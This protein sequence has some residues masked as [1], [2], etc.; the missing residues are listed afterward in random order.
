[1][2]TVLRILVLLT[3][4]V[5]V[6]MELRQSVNYRPE[7][8][9]VDRAST[10]NLV[11]MVA[12]GVLVASF[13]LRNVPSAA[14]GPVTAARWVALVL[15]WAGIALRQWSFRTLGRYFTFTIET[16]GDQPVIATGPYRVL[17]HPSYTGLLLVLVGIGLLLG[18]WLSLLAVAVAATAAL[19]YR[20]GVEE[21][22]LEAALGDR[23]REYAATRKRLIPYVW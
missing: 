17:R 9:S 2:P 10:R 3:G 18:N 14:I 11:L 21:R 4:V 16:S 5:W 8:T 13:A 1:V 23:Y 22:A 20:I 7:A 19:V 12:A 6:G 15:L